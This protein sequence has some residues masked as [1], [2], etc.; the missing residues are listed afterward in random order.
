MEEESLTQQIENMKR[1]MLEIQSPAPKQFNLPLVARMSRGKVMKK[2]WVH[3]LLIKNNGSILVKT[4]RIEDDTVKFGDYY[5][6]ARAGNVLRW[7]G[8]P[9]LILKE[10]NISPEVPPTQH[11]F[12]SDEDYK[13]AEAQ[14]KLTT[15]LGLIFT[16]MK[17]DAIKGAM[18]F[19]MGTILMIVVVLAGGYFGLSALGVI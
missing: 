2:D 12:S 19:N 18:N 1:Q 4:L 10:W 16:K 13:K 17:K 9:F 8:M 7:K 5:Y 15:P 14:G 11:T 6:D 3:C